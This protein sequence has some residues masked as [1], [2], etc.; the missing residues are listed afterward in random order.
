MPDISKDTLNQLYKKMGATDPKEKVKIMNKLL[1]K[2]VSVEG[3]GKHVEIP[4]GEPMTYAG[5][6]A[7]GFADIPKVA[8]GA[9]K[10]VGGYALGAVPRFFGGTAGEVIGGVGDVFQGNIAQ[11]LSRATLSPLSGATSAA[12]QKTI[13]EL[14][15]S[16]GDVAGMGLQETG[17]GLQQIGSGFQRL[18]QG[19]I[20]GGLTGL[21][22]GTVKGISGA[23]GVVASPIGAALEKTP[24][25]AGLAN[26]GQVAGM[27]GRAGVGALGVDPE[28]EL[29]RAMMGTPAAALSLYGAGRMFKGNYQSMKDAVKGRL[30]QAAG[31][32]SKATSAIKGIPQVMKNLKAQPIPTIQRGLEKATPIAAPI[33][34]AEKGI[35]GL[36]K[37]M[38]YDLPKSLIN[39]LKKPKTPTQARIYAKVGNILQEKD[40]TKF[41]ALAKGLDDIDTKGV[42]T[43]KDLYNRAG[44]TAN[45]IQSTKK[46]ILQAIR[47]KHKLKDLAL[48]QAD[49]GVT[50]KTNYVQK[51]FDQLDDYYKKTEQPVQ[52]KKLQQ[53]KTKAAKAGLSANEIDDLAIQYNKNVSGMKAWTATGKPKKGLTAQAVENTRKGLKETARSFLP[54]DATKIMDQKI[55]NVLKVRDL[56]DDLQK[57][58]QNLSNKVAPPSGALEGAAEFS[59]KLANSLTAGSL[60]GFAKALQISNVGK[61]TF[62]YLGIE[63]ALS[64]NLKALDVLNKNLSKVKGPITPNKFIE[65]IDGLSKQ[66]ISPSVVSNLK[67]AAKASMAAEAIKS[68]TPKKKKRGR[69]D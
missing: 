67:K 42:K 12:F 35:L 24:I 55:S 9:A 61:K 68:T 53:L 54:D 47:G 28:S 20:G 43:Y 64:K 60:Q 29:G 21:Y 11:G 30:S 57:K 49:D 36:Q 31:I 34:K 65:V 56:A 33:I 41:A 19:D 58:V 32:K 8:G 16:A 62:N 50:V 66:K 48:Q 38:A 46:G 40:A 37:K 1:S 52:L 4:K 18:G 3:K 23:T 45:A 5:Q 27:A 17:A 51:A 7:Q 15:R 22:G 13:P 39:K 69:L 10:N 59:V 44:E 6:I 63:N 25:G 14:A 26:V 2:G